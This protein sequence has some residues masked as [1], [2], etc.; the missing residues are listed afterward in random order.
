MTILVT[1]INEIQLVKENYFV[2][3]SAP[4]ASCHSKGGG[5]GGGGGAMN[6]LNT[7]AL[8]RALKYATRSVLLICFRS[9]VQGENKGLPYHVRS[10][11]TTQNRILNQPQDLH[12]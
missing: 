12:A 11:S 2:H 7:N 8:R 4:T 6:S 3:I 9:V 5:G 10:A 1:M